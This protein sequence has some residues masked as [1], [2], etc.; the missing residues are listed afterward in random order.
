V[1]EAPAGA[2]R[3][4]YAIALGAASALLFGASTPVSKILLAELTPLQLAGLLY[5]GG[6]LGVFILAALRGRIRQL[7]APRDRVNRLRLGGAVVLGGGI[8][9]VLLLFGLWLARASSVSLILNLE[10]AF[11]AVLGVWLFHEPLH[12]RGWAGVAGIV[13][14]GALV[15]WGGGTPGIEAGLLVAGACLCWAFDNH[16]TALIDGITPGASTFW[17]GLAAG[18]VNL[19]LG[20][21]LDDFY[22]PWNIVAGTLAVGALAYGLSISLYI[23]SAQQLGATRAQGL[24]ATSP[25]LGAALAFVAL[26]E[27][28][29]AVHG[30]AML[31]MAVSVAVLVLSQHEHEHS[32]PA[33]EHVHSHTHDDGHHLHEHEGLPAGTRHSHWHKH[34]PM[35]HRHPHW[36]DVHHRHEHPPAED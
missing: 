11:T 22:A 9:P 14:A 16:W 2:G 31:V 4:S 27:P 24:F 3:R 10:L 34:E 36:P 13:A 26:G 20:L 19:G 32:H 7:R 12:R 1:S 6:A 15:S 29:T 25:F 23:A 5:L 21:L 17:K 18:T 28:L 33:M 8:G 35:R 30:V